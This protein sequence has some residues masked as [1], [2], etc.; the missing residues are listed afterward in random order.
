[1]VLLFV[2]RI[3][4]GWHPPE[5]FKMP[6]QPTSKKPEVD[7]KQADNTHLMKTKNAESRRNIQQV[8]HLER[9]LFL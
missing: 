3:N 4:K 7:M 6:H 1:M 5:S 2:Q 8:Y 9:R